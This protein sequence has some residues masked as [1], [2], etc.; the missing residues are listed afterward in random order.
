MSHVVV[1]ML[2]SGQEIIGRFD[3][4]GNTDYT[5]AD[6]AEVNTITLQRVRVVAP[7][8]HP[9]GRIQVSLMPYVFSNIDT[10][11][12]IAT[13]HIVGFP[14]VASEAMEREYLSQTTSIALS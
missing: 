6:E 11:V 3:P 10:D 12:Q 5:F 13:D 8:Q 14:R 2:A 7:M 4:Q 9:D 1:L